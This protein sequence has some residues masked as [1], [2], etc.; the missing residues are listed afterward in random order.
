[1]KASIIIQCGD[2]KQNPGPFLKYAECVKTVG[3][4]FKNNVKIFSLNCRSIVGQN[5]TLK[6]LMDDLGKN[7][8]FGFTET[9]LK[10]N[11]DIRF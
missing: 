5:S 2:V 6:Q 10:M 9:W 8:I 11:D 1:M 4:S 3:T 7:T